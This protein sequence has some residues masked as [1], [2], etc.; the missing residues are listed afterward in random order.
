MSRHH[1][2]DHKSRHSEHEHGHVHEHASSGCT[3]SHSNDGSSTCCSKLPSSKE[4]MLN[5]VDKH[6]DRDV[7]RGPT[8]FERIVLTVG[9]LKCG[10]CETGLSKALRQ[11]PS[12]KNHHVNVV[13]ARIEFDL[14]TS[15]LSIPE[16]ILQLHKATGYM[17][18]HYDQPEGQVLELLVNDPAEIH[19]AGRPYGVILIDSGEKQLRTPSIIFSGRNSAIPPEVSTHEPLAHNRHHTIERRVAPSLFLRTVRVHYDA[20][21]I[22]ARDV[23]EYYQQL[24]PNQNLQLAPGGA[25]PG[26]AVG[27]QQTKRACTI[28]LITLVFTIPVLVFAWMPTYQKNFADDHAQLALATIVQIIATYEF[29]PGAIQTLIHSK[30]FE[31]DFL[32]AISTT[33]AYIFSVVSYTFQIKGTPLEIGSFF[34]TSTLLVTLILL[35]RAVSEFARFRA[36]KSVS[37]RSLQTQEA[38]LIIS[39][40]SIRSGGETRKIDARLLQ[41]G[42][43]FKVPPHSR[44]VTDGRVVY[45]GSEVDESMITGESVPVAKGLGHNVHAGTTNGDGQLV[46]SLT[47]L[48]HENSISR[49]ATMVENAELSKPRAQAL[50]DKVAGMFVP[51]IASIGTVVFFIWIVVERHFHHRSWRTAVV[52]ALTYAISTLIV[53]CPCAIGLAVPMVILIAGGMSARYGVIF[54]DPQKLETARDATDIIFDKTGTLTTGELSVVEG[55]FHGS[56]PKQVKSMTM[57]LLENDKH[58]VAA[59]I[60]KWLLVESNQGDKTPILPTKMIDVRS[61]PGNGVVGMCEESKVEVRAGNPQWLGVSVL[62]SQ[63]TLLCITV[64]GVLSATF[65]LEDRARH[66]ADKVIDLLSARGIKVHLISGDSEGAVNEIAHTLNIPKARTRW[67]QKPKDKARYIHELQKSGN[68]VV[69]CGDGTNDS[70]A[71]KQADVGVHMSHGSDVAK[72]ASDVVLMTT[73]LHNM[74][75]LLDISKAAYR[76]IIMNFTWSAIYNVVAVLMA[77]G[78][79]VK[80]RI[81]PAYAGLGELVSVLPVVLI[82]F[83]LR[84]RDYGKKYRMMQYE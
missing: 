62:E 33:T 57:G 28:F 83:Q 9:G 16:A 4:V 29:V 18:E 79:F 46:V 52:K 14:D 13:L 80:F 10:C 25:H 64:S 84:W 1:H 35:G 37:I 31:M 63:H 8:T 43:T 30:I 50:A 44:I 48:P 27:A 49:I 22:G 20:K 69:F 40:D 74:L 76:R 77:A 82:A 75:I 6:T 26:L 51:I 23:F 54:R 67:R 2:S 39:S 38:L 56:N 55:E 3:S 72:S 5:E 15:Q 68:T 47:K 45:G 7:E 71:L 53:S 60:R 11:F 59:A 17:F 21:Q 61:E 81:A 42:D 58:P 41:Y 19:R 12:I 65:R 36:A 24:A 73:Q 32:I 66:N 70:V 34:E 78:A